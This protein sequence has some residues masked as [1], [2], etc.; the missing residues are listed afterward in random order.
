MGKNSITNLPDFVS[1]IITLSSHWANEC[2]IGNN[3]RAK[4]KKTRI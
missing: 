4:A 1:K 3:A 2:V